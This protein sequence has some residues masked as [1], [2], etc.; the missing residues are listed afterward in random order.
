[1]TLT[2]VSCMDQ[3]S[4]SSC[5]LYVFLLMILLLQLYT[6]LFKIGTYRDV[7]HFIELDVIRTCTPYVL[8]LSRNSAELICIM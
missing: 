6:Q 1:M 4:C 7:L 3:L 8:L 2:R 5:I